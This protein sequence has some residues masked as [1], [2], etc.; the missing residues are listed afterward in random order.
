M[1]VAATVERRGSCKGEMK[2]HEGD[3][4]H[5]AIF[6]CFIYPHFLNADKNKCIMHLTLCGALENVH[7]LYSCFYYNAVLS[8]HQRMC[9][10]LE[11][12]FHL[13]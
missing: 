13:R 9:L 3:K 11:N 8:L 4:G 10:V 12:I 6:S 1:R 7:Y 2:G 5:L